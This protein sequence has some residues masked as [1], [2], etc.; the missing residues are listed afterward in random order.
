MNERELDRLLAS[1]VDDGPIEVPD[2]VIETALAEI[3]TTPQRGRSALPWRRPMFKPLAI[4]IAT[5]LLAALLAI[6]F[7]GGAIGPSPSP[8]PS[9]TVPLATIRT[10]TT[11]EFELP[12]AFPLRQGAIIGFTV[13]EAPTMVTIIPPG[14]SSDRL[15]LMPL[16]GTRVVGDG[17]EGDAASLDALVQLLDSRPGIKARQL[18]RSDVDQPASFPVSGSGAFVVE[19]DTDPA[20]AEP[21]S[22]LLRTSAGETIDV[23]AEPWTYWIVPA[24]GT[25][26]GDLLVVYHGSTS[27]FGNYGQTFLSLLE[28]IQPVSE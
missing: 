27:D 5:A 20:A 16:E 21:G 11:S 4:V 1:A 14:S 26:V 24:S 17:E 13:D 25:A 18:R 3:P 19:V 15:V 6:P 10:Y 2:R 7:V 8:T 23:A 9:P 12:I 22:P 28:D